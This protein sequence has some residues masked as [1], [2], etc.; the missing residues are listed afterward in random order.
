M[1]KRVVI[2][3]SPTCGGAERVSVT[4]AKSLVAAGFDVRI[5][6]VGNR[7]GEIME[8][9]PSRIQ[10]FFV[11]T[12]NIWDF[13]VLKLR[14]LFRQ[15]RPDFVFCS[16]MYLNPRVI[17]AAKLDRRTKV[18]VRNNIS[19]DRMSRI[20]RLLIRRS[21]PSADGIILQTDE[22]KQEMIRLLGRRHESGM[23]VIP[24][25]IDKETIRHCLMDSDSV[26]SKEDVSYLYIGRIDYSKGLDTLIKAFEVVTHRNSRARLLIIGKYSPDDAYYRQLRMME[27]GEGISGRVTWL[28]FQNNPYVYLR[29]ADCLVL[30]S[31]AEGLPNVVLEAMYLRVPV[32]VTRSVPVIDRLVPKDRG[33]VVDVDNPEQFAWGMINALELDRPGPFSDNSEKMFVELFS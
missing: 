19:I 32:V 27:E 14:H 18:F 28:G 9:I 10:V 5:A 8:F 17:L 20:T 4:V 13:T 2:C 30:P 31:R 7:R 33:V 23:H 3:V 22:M 26:L 11:H 1:S 21:Y 25:P 12:R 24:N 6:I 16:L 29:D 15:L